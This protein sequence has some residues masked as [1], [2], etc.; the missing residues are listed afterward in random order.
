[1]SHRSRVLEAL[2]PESCVEISPADARRLGIQPGD[3]ITLHSRRGQVETRARETLR[4]RPGMA[5]MAFHWADAP[6]NVL[7]NPAV[8][9]L[10]KIPEFK[11]SSVRAVLTVLERAAEDSAFLAALAENPAEALKSFDLTAEQ[12][13]A[14]AAGDIAAIERLVGRLDERL[15]VWLK[16]RLEQEV[17]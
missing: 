6:A 7:T 10:A 16:R 13:A 8:D 5:F 2:E 12:R 15:K 17:W 4:V 9:P 1:M 14:L 11:V 3:V